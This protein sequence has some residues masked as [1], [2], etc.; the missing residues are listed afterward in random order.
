M[1]PSRVSLSV[2]SFPHD[3][4]QESLA[5]ATSF[6][7]SYTQKFGSSAECGWKKDAPL[8]L[9]WCQADV[10]E[11][12]RIVTVLHHLIA[13]AVTGK[14]YIFTFDSLREDW[15]QSWPT[16]T[17]MLKSIDVDPSY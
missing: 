10:E 1:V 2:V 5:Y 15:A 8:T 14:L 16:I 17:T 7:A 6:A 11:E 12:G 3:R 9:F 13:N 4:P